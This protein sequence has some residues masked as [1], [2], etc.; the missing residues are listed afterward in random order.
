[1]GLYSFITKDVVAENESKRVIVVLRVLYLIMQVVFLLQVIVA[2]PDLIK[3]FP[4][5]VLGLVLMNAGFFAY[6]YFC[7]T[8]PA[9]VLFISY[10]FMWIFWMMPVMGWRAGFQNGFIIVLVLV[11]FAGHSA[12]FEKL[13]ICGAILAIR[14]FSTIYFT[15]VE[16]RVPLSDVCSTIIQIVNITGVYIAIVFISYTF[17]KTENDAEIKLIKYNDKLKLE[18]NTDQLTGLFNRRRALE[19]LESITTGGEVSAISIAMGDIDFFKKVNDTYGHD[20]GDEVLKNV[21]QIMRDSSRSTSFISRWGGEEF[22]IVFPECNG[23]HAF[24][25]LERLRRTIQNQATTVG[26]Q[27][28]SVTMTFGLAE[29]DFNKDIDSAIKEADEK[30]YQGKTSGRN[31]VVY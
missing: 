29:Y 16:P 17:S 27:E 7:R 19:Y 22:L 2:G 5:R 8:R 9:L 11:F 26:G 12:L 28:I 21:A 30:L 13:A 23:D 10:I 24:I 25:A 31:R 6:T 18:A 3:G 1:M 14:I 15:G 4:V 20:A